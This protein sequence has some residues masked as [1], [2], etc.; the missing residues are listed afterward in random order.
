MGSRT[1]LSWAEKHAIVLY[2][3]HEGINGG[4]RNLRKEREWQ[5]SHLKI[6]KAPSY[7]TVL[8]IIEDETKI[9]RFM[10]LYGYKRKK[11]WCAQNRVL[12]EQLRAW[13]VEMWGRGVSLM[14]FII[15]E[16]GHQLQC[17]Y[18]AVVPPSKRTHIVF[19]EGWLYLFKKRHGFKCHRSHGE[20]GDADKTA[21]RIALPHLRQLA[22]QYPYTDIYNADEFGLW[23]SSAPTS[24]I[25][26]G[27]LEGWKKVRHVS[28]F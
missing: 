7:K 2:C 6:A 5:V 10:N 18:N 4:T 1:R 23:Y 19:S 17:A 26:P 25:G 20:S 21:A 15:R 27:P 12:E 8:R 3:K 13:V 9:V 28:R 22:A 24:T 16:K 11:V 14:D